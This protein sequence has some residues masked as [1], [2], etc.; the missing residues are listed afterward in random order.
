MKPTHLT[1]FI[2]ATLALAAALHAAGVRGVVD[3][4]LEGVQ[5]YNQSIEDAMN[6]NTD[7]N[8]LPPPPVAPGTIKSGWL[9]RKSREA[10]PKDIRLFFAYPAALTKAKPT[11]GLIVLQEWW[12]V[13]D[14]MQQRLAI[15]PLQRLLCRRPRSL[16]QQSH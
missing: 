16:Q 10:T 4:K 1:P 9:T 13:N 14:D 5:D 8:K 3:R 11:A 6:G 15:W 7:D 12:G 2:L